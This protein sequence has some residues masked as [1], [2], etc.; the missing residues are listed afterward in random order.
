MELLGRDPTWYSSNRGAERAIEKLLSFKT[1][2]LTRRSSSLLRA[3][4]LDRLLISFLSK[5]VIIIFFE[6]SNLFLKLRILLVIWLGVLCLFNWLS[7][8]RLILFFLLYY[9][10]GDK[11]NFF[12]FWHCL[13]ICDFRR[14]FYLFDNRLLFSIWDLF[15]LLWKILDLRKVWKGDVFYIRNIVHSLVLLNILLAPNDPLLRLLIGGLE[16]ADSQKVIDCFF[17]LFSAFIGKTSSKESFDQDVDVFDVEGSVNDLGAVLN[18]HLLVLIFPIA[19]SDVAKDSC[20]LLGD[21]FLEDT[22]VLICD[23]QDFSGILVKFNCLC[24]RAFFEFDIRLFFGGIH[25][26]FNLFELW[27]QLL[28][29]SAIHGGLGSLNWLWCFFGCR[30]WHWCRLR[31]WRTRRCWG[32]RSFFCF[33]ILIHC[34]IDLPLG[35]LVASN[36]F[37]GRINFLA[38]WFQQGLLFLQ[39]C[40]LLGVFLSSNFCVL[41]SFGSVRQQFALLLL[42]RSDLRR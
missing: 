14:L 21:L 37:Y 40:L 28:L 19:K 3:E 23:L 17:V 27:L 18:L 38:D 2:A 11:L 4:V 15:F 35:I 16:L 34:F 26:N 25:L 13:N 12:Y 7:L 29:L 20:L 22:E 6:G 5:L 10:L 24:I 33:K 8:S 41:L 1:H 39:L 36:I 32:S 42:E 30:Y 31:R 9:V